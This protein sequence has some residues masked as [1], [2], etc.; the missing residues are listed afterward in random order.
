MKSILKIISVVCLCM[1]G[2]HATVFSPSPADKLRQQA[3][4]LEAKNEALESQVEEL[5][6][7]LAI[8]S[9]SATKTP[10]AELEE[11][12]PH[13]CK[14]SIGNLSRALPKKVSDGHVARPEQL[15]IFVNAQDGRGGAIQLTGD[16]TLQASLQSAGKVIPLAAAHWGPLQLRDVYR[17]GLGNPH[18]SL[19]T[20]IQVPADC[21]DATALVVVT[22]VDGWSGR[23][24]K[25][26]RAIPWPIDAFTSEKSAKVEPDL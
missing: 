12:T 20:P 24:L 6:A 17:N 21:A 3:Q 13:V 16:L 10:S 7:Q 23:T 1:G 14:I 19:E 18:Y 5:R 25:T 4:E 22:Y 9:E 2:C 15:V 8:K 26:E 11:A